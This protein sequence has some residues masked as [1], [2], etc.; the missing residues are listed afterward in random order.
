MNTS[1][2]RGY[3]QNRT[4]PEGGD[5]YARHLLLNCAFGYFGQKGYHIILPKG[6][7]DV[8]VKGVG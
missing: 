5:Y 6:G 3:V 4:D 1:S 2:V 7:I 8:N